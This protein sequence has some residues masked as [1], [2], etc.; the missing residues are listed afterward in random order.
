[1]DMS[2]QAAAQ[3]QD[4]RSHRSHYQGPFDPELTTQKMRSML[5]AAARHGHDAVVLG[6]Y[7]CGAFQHDPP[8]IAQCFSALLG[9][10]G[11]FHGV[12][13]VVLFAVIK[14]EAN[15][16]GFLTV[17]PELEAIPPNPTRG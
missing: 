14:S 3:A 2:S 8:T 12:F 15:L 13:R 4:L 11:E 5:W 9:P 1:M 7:G 10:G 17:F 16:R 6:A